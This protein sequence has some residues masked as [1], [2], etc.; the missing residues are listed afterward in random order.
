MCKLTTQQN[1]LRK[2]KCV[3]HT[4]QAPLPCQGEHICSEQ[5]KQESHKKLQVNLDYLLLSYFVQQVQG[6][7]LKTVEQ[8]SNLKFNAEWKL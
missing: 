6:V 1:I 3:Y 7:Y 8:D 2:L 5:T 4:N